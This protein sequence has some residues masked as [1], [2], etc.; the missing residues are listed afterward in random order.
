MEA[1]IRQVVI[2]SIRAYADK[3]QSRGKLLASKETQT[4]PDYEELIKN[5]AD[6]ILGDI[7]RHDQSVQAQINCAVSQAVEKAK[8]D[9]LSQYEDELAHLNN[10]IESL[11]GQLQNARLVDPT[12]KTIGILEAK[13]SNSSKANKV[14][15][16][17]AENLVKAFKELL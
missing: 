14:L 9:C 16:Q 8:A 10:V 15:I 11:R 5:C 3:F 13:L 2:E 1:H 12:N 4:L 7:R 17:T 6:D